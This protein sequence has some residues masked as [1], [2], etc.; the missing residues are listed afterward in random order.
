M[1]STNTRPR[2]QSAFPSFN[3]M[4]GVLDDKRLSIVHRTV[5]VRVGLH[6]RA[7]NGQCTPGYSAIA[8]E[9]GVHRATIFRAIDVGVKAGWLAPRADHG[10]RTL[11]HFALTFPPGQP[12]PGSDGSAPQ[13]S[14]GCDGSENPTIAA[15]RPNR[16]S[17]ATQPSQRQ[18]DNPAT[19]TTSTR[20]GRLNG[21]LERG[22]K[23]LSPD[24]VAPRVKET[25]ARVKAADGKKRRGKVGAADVGFTAFWNAYPKRVAEEAALKAFIAAVQRGA[26]PE[27]LVAGARRYAI[28]QAEENPRFT[29]HAETWLRKGCWTDQAPGAPVLD[30]D[31]N[32]VAFAARWRG[33]KTNWEV[34]AGLLAASGDTDGAAEM[35]EARYG[36]D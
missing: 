14:H 34:A 35:M 19:S 28:E 17:S 10:G 23:T 16:R 25:D 15:V 5:L 31:G 33:E 18:R 13:P 8:A 3:W 9:L 27:A 4:R 6:R 11:A 22:N 1:T 26:D 21:R 2:A 20:N 7:D 24:L 32:V 30:N 29:K 36:R 12:S